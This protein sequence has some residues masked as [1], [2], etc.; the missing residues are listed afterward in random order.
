MTVLEVNVKKIT[1][2]C[3]VFKHLARHS[4]SRRGH[5][6]WAALDQRSQVPP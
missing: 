5:E 6:Q 2:R 3:M 4:F 1:A